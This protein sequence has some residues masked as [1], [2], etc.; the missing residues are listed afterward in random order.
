MREQRWNI[1]TCLTHDDEAAPDPVY[2]RARDSRRSTM[3]DDIYRYIKTAVEM[4]LLDPPDTDSQRGYLAALM[5]LANDVLGLD[6]NK[7]PFAE[8]EK[9]CLTPTYRM[10][11]LRR[12]V[13]W[14]SQE[15]KELEE[16]MGEQS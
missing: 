11:R 2:G 14:R 9:V 10:R 13:A 4:F 8:A 5:V 15:L 16:L 7:K 12:E 3:S 6:M 1:V